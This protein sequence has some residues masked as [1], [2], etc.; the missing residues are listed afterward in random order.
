MRG[1]PRGQIQH[2]RRHDLRHDLHVQVGLHHLRLGRLPD[3]HRMQ[4]GTYTATGASCLNCTGPEAGILQNALLIA[5][6]VPS[7][8]PSLHPGCQADL[9]SCPLTSRLV[10][11]HGLSTQTAQPISTAS[12]RARAHVPVLVQRPRADPANT[13]APRHSPPAH[14]WHKC[15]TS[16]RPAPRGIFVYQLVIMYTSRAYWRV[17]TGVQTVGT[18]GSGKGPHLRTAQRQRRRPAGP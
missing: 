12:W 2:R 3:L 9:C 17:Q 5:A 7:S 6:L 16:R 14:R 11:S 4:A 15:A 8:S 10:L 13:R 1:V 18:L